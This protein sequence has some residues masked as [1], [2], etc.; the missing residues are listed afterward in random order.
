MT[1]IEPPELTEIRAWWKR[2]ISVCDHSRAFTIAGSRCDQTMP[3]G[4][5]NPYWEIVRNLPSIKTDWYGVTP[6]SRPDQLS[7]GHRGRLTKRFSWSIPSPGDVAWLEQ[8]LDGRGVVEIGAGA[9]YWAWQ[10][11]Q[12]RIDVVAYEP[13]EPADNH[14]VHGRVYTELRRG[15]HEA[16][17]LHPDRALLICWPTNDAPWASEAL[18]AYAGDTL[19]YIGE[20][21]GGCCA[22]DGFF[23]KID[24]GWTEVDASTHHVSWWGVHCGMTAYRRG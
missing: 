6:Y 15:G 17:A 19:I 5:D 10:A 2:G 22:D 18:A 9:G 13:Q 21:P 16:A 8:I 1:I 14:D 4:M 20:G 11:R 24:G 7:V 12:A 3:R 23:E